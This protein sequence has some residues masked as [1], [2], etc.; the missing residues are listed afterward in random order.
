MFLHFVAIQFLYY[1]YQLVFIPL[2]ENEDFL[3]YVYILQYTMILNMVSE[4][5]DQSNVCE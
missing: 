5:P 1:S 4:G 2:C 3:A